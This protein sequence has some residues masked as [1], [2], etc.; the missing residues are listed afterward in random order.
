MVSVIDFE[1]VFDTNGIRVYKPSKALFSKLQLPSSTYIMCSQASRDILYSPYL[2]GKELQEKMKEVSKNFF[3]VISGLGLLKNKKKQAMTELVFLAGGLYYYLNH[4]F[5]AIFDYALPQCFIG[6]QRARVEGS[7]GQFIA[8]ISYENYES[9]PNNA[10]IFIGDTIATGATITKGILSLQSSLLEKNYVLDE[11]HV[12]S[13]ACSTTGACKLGE[14]EQRLKSIFKQSKINLFVT[15]QLFTLMEDGTD[16]RFLEKDSIMPQ[17][18]YDYTLKTYGT[19][20]GKNMKCAVFD[21]GTRCKNPLKHY[22]EFIDYASNTLKDKSIPQEA[23]VI[24]S[25]M[26][27]KAQQSLEE[28]LATL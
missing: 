3:N 22:H 6:I 2:A 18:T 7:V 8:K 13:L 4:G 20:L 19:W 16:L 14:F 10:I 12:F 5:K 26:K 27:I 11:I 23:K 24:L 9:L 17:E 21:W 1:K 15:E 25:E 28:S